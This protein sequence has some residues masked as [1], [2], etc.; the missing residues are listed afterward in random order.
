MNVCVIGNSHVGALKGAWNSL[1]S[2]HREINITFFASR[3]NSLSDLFYENGKLA[4]SS[5]RVAEFLSYTSGGKREIVLED[6]DTFLLYGIGAVP[7]RV[8]SG[9]YSQAVL[10]QAIQD[11]YEDRLFFQIFRS[12]R[13]GS[14]SKIVIGHTPLRSG[15]DIAEDSA[16]AEELSD[17][18]KSISTINEN[19]FLPKN[20]EFLTQ[21]A[22]TISRGGRYTHTK[23]TRGSE[24]LAINEKQSG[25]SHPDGDYGHMNDDYGK[26]YLDK[27]LKKIVN[28]PV[29][30]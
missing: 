3:G 29:S 6:Y 19:L 18:R 4:S 24:R 8:P 13:K 14:D 20:G 1:S 15:P 26:V 7:Y 27:L 2:I 12:I 23:F 22:E 5:D 16:T 10:A 9:F 11:F 17:Y 21:P 28:T 25:L 30:A